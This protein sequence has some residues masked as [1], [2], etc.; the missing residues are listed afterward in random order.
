MKMKY[1]PQCAFTLVEIMIVVAIVGLLSAIAIPSFVSARTQSREKVCLNSLRQL[2]GAK[3][4]VALELGLGDGSDVS[5]F[6]VTYL[7]K[8]LPVC[9][10]G[11]T[12][13]TLNLVG[14]PPECASTAAAQHNAAYQN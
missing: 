10:V 4:Q 5:A 12:D 1:A 6:V 14:T 7:K 9:P 13:Y 8:G 2:D 3:D 11:D